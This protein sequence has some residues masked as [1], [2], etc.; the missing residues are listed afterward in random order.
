MKNER[1]FRAYF[2]YFVSMLCLVLLR[3]ASALGWLDSISAKIGSSVAF[4]LFAQCFSM[5]LVPLTLYFLLLT[6]RGGRLK[7]LKTDFRLNSIRACN[8]PEI[9]VITFATIYVTTCISAV[10]Q[11]VLG[12]IGFRSGGTS[13][14]TGGGIDFVISQIFI[15]AVLPAIFEE[16]TNRGVLGAAEKNEK[17]YILFS[18]L[19]FALMH[20]N[21][22]QTGYT[23]VA[24]LVMAA[25]CF[26]TNGIWASVF[27][28]FMNNFISVLRAY[29]G[30][31]DFLNRFF[32]LALGGGI[33]SVLGALLFV[34]SVVLIVMSFCRIKSRMPKKPPRYTVTEFCSFKNFADEKPNNREK[35]FL[36]L[37][38]G[39]NSAA[40]IFSLV[41]GLLR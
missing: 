9:L 24:G 2:V 28:H 11:G 13:G 37:T 38:V 40:T 31:L 20:Q 39:M 29:T 36:W 26:Y 30:A 12:L 27:F 19:L 5:G 14:G 4:S 17:E 16:L 34:M 25:L 41:W 33:G 22:T 15:V 8:F 21:V 23:F 7:T 10:W 18:A 3:A 32:G 35:I 6:K 1:T